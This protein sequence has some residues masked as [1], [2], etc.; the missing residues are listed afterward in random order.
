MWQVTLAKLL[1]VKI[2]QLAFRI[3]SLLVCMNIVSVVS[4][5]DSVELR[6]DVDLCMDQTLMCLWVAFCKSN[7]AGSRKWLSP[8]RYYEA[9]MVVHKNVK[10]IGNA[11]GLN[12]P[13]NQAYGKLMS[14]SD[15]FNVALF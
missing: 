15:E 5:Y 1:S 6:A 4:G 9:W 14:I 3:N 2:S 7:M 8:L 13:S 12:E 11:I 10:I